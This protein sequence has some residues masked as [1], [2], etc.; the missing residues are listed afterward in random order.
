MSAVK[1]GRES[2]ASDAAGGDEGGRASSSD[3]SV[4]GVIADSL[5]HYVERRDVYV[6]YCDEETE[7]YCDKAMKWPPQEDIVKDEYQ[8]T[9]MLGVFASRNLAARALRRASDAVLD[10]L[11]NINADWLYHERYIPKKVEED[12][13]AV[14]AWQAQKDERIR[15]LRSGDDG[16]RRFFDLRK[17]DPE[18]LEKTFF[19]ALASV[20]TK[21]SY[22]EEWPDEDEGSCREAAADTGII[23]GQIAFTLAEE[24]DT[25]YEEYK[26]HFVSTMTR[27]TFVIKRS[28]VVE[29]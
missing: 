2:G 1:R 17:S 20:G 24:R 26:E 18:L 14:A 9:R 5:A 19:S 22:K 21:I 10:S 29:S 4:D 16:A 12:E 8:F 3:P 27:C 7:T 15:A 6:A 11:D 25:R 28:A 13:A 23:V